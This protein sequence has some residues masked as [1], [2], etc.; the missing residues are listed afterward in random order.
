LAVTF[1]DCQ[2]AGIKVLAFFEKPVNIKLT[3]YGTT[4]QLDII[5]IGDGLENITC[6]Y[7]LI[8]SLKGQFSNLIISPIAEAVQ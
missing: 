1:F 3:G 7:T 5:S 6:R 8:F 4:V 2:I